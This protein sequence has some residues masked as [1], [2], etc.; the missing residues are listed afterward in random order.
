MKTIDFVI[1]VLDEMFFFVSSF[2]LGRVYEGT[3]AV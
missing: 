1:S 3:K 2:D